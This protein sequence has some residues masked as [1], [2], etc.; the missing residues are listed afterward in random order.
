VRAKIENPTDPHSLALVSGSRTNAN[1]SSRQFS[2]SCLVS[3]PYE[4]FDVLGEEDLALLSRRFKRMYTNRKNARRSSGMSYRCGK[5]GHFIAKCPEAMEVKAEHKHYSKTYRL[6]SFYRL[7]NPMM[8]WGVDLR[9]RAVFRSIRE[10]RT[11]REGPADGPRGANSSRVLRVLARLRFRSVVALSFC[12]ARFRT[13]RSSGRTVRGCLADSPRAPRG[14]SVIQRR[15]WR[16]CLLFRTVRGEGPD[17]PWCVRGQSAA[18]GRTVRVASADGPPLLAVRSA[19]ACVLCFL[20][21]F[22][23]S[24]LVLPRVLQG[25]VPKTRG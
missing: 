22:L 23:P 24:S 4:E 18:A 16:F 21:R 2:L 8:I 10:A 1:M 13:V 6:H 7:G 12:W 9:G 15:L 25:I 20:V 5:H 14:R 19:R 3:M 11:V 17:G